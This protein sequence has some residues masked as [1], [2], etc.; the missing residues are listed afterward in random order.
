MFNKLFITFYG[1]ILPYTLTPAPNA[2]KQKDTLWFVS[3]SLAW[4]L[5]C[6]LVWLKQCLRHWGS[7]M[8]WPSRRRSDPMS[9][10]VNWVGQLSDLTW[11]WLNSTFSATHSKYTHA[12]K[13]LAAIF[14]SMKTSWNTSHVPLSAQKQQ[15]YRLA[16]QIYESLPKFPGPS[17]PGP[18]FPRVKRWQKGIRQSPLFV[19]LTVA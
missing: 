8:A 9:Q 4:R 13:V 14:R 11:S 7:A 3:L 6:S 16:V 10:L 5:L 2:I 1:K 12:L 19:R 18:N 17:Y 15:K